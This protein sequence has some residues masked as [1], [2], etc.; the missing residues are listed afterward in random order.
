MA[1]VIPGAIT[2]GAAHI[3]GGITGE[4]VVISGTITGGSGGPPYPGPYVITP[5]QEAQVLPISGKAAREDI[6]VEPIPSNYGLV[7]W[8]G[9]VL[10]VS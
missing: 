10:T 5:S 8:N 6:I 7:T 2:G 4:R 3:T 9:S 1:T